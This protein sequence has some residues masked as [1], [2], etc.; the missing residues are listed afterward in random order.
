MKQLPYGR[1]AYR[2]NYSSILDA[3]KGTCSTKH[4][5]IAALA[6]ELNISLELHMGIFLLTPSTMPNTESIL[7]SYQLEAIPES[8]C[9][10]KYASRT[11]DITFPHLQL[12][13]FD[14]DLLQEISMTLEKIGSFKVDYHQQFIRRW[15]KDKPHLTFDQVWKA[16]E[17]W[18][19]NL[20]TNQNK[21]NFLII[22]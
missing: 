10:L 22:E 14:A 21:N 1:I 11:L 9:Y 15:I 2:E 4:A 19:K 12:F 6:K 16:R 7:K 3:G 8:H 20:N 18:I 5:L 17:E 13:S